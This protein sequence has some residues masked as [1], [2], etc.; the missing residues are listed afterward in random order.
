MFFDEGFAHFHF[1]GVQGMDF[2][3]FQG[4]GQFKI[5]GMVIGSMQGKFI[6]GLF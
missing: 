2:G 6:V 5:N 3:D 1:Q 4:E